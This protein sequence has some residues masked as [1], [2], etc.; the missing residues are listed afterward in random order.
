MVERLDHLVGTML[1]STVMT[2]FDVIDVFVV[3][4]GEGGERR[5]FV[6]CLL[7]ILC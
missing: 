4:L 6:Y 1:L 5:Y 2:A 3:S 7:D